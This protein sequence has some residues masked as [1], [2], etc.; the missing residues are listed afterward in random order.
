VDAEFV[1]ALPGRPFPLAFGLVMRIGEKYV[2]R[3]SD[4][5]DDDGGRGGGHG[6]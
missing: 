2:G 4:G 5:D 1:G 6:W 3:G